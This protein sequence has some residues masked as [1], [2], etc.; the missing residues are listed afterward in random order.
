MTTILSDLYAIIQ[1]RQLNPKP[2]S[3]T[4]RLFELGLPEIAKKVGEEGVEVVVAALG[5]NRE[6]LISELA[7]LTY[8]A[9]VLLVQMGISYQDVLDELEKRHK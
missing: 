3:Y 1:E 2:G 4:N 7:D 9:T 6:R 5:Q 8:H